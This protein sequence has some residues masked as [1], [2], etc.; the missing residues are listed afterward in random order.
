MH[1]IRLQHYKVVLDYEVVFL[2][3][4]QNIR[5][6]TAFTAYIRTDDSI[7]SPKLQI[8]TRIRVRFTDEGI[9]IP[10]FEPLVT[11]YKP[12]ISSF[13]CTVQRLAL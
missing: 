11:L 1:T 13:N 9:E 12:S 7:Y 5:M 2:F 4:K 6:Q 3:S 10:L 8:F